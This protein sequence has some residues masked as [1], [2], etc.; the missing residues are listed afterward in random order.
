VNKEQAEKGNFFI[1]LICVLAKD[2]HEGAVA[3]RLVA[4]SDAL[5][6]PILYLQLTFARS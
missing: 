4:I 1:P 2:R 3:W 5:Q 6:M